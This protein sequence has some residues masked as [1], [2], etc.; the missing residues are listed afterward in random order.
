[1]KP[2]SKYHLAFN[3]G[4]PNA[5]DRTHGRTGSHIMIH[6]DKVSIGCLAMTDEKIEEIFT[7]CAAA[8][9]HG[10]PFFRVHLFP[11]RMTEKRLQQTADSEWHPFWQNLKQGYDWF[12]NHRIPPDATV[13]DGR[14]RFAAAS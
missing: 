3:L 13:E 12:E 6:G 11:F 9:T 4:F 1:M 5:Y 7:L 2:D 10:Q 8:H 14:Y